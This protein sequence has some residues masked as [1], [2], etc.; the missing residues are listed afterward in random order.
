[1]VYQPSSRASPVYSLSLIHS[2]PEELKEFQLNP[3]RDARK[4]RN[5]KPAHE[6]IYLR[7]RFRDGLDT[8]SQNFAPYNLGFQDHFDNSPFS[9]GQGPAITFEEI[10]NNSIGNVGDPNNADNS[11]QA[12]KDGQ[13]YQKTQT[14]ANDSNGQQPAPTVRFRKHR[15]KEFK[16]SVIKFFRERLI[17]CLSCISDAFDIDDEFQ[18]RKKRKPKNGEAGLNS[19][20]RHTSSTSQNIGNSNHDILHHEVGVPSI[21]NYTHKSHPPKEKKNNKPMTLTPPPRLGMQEPPQLLTEQ[22]LVTRARTE[23]SRSQFSYHSPIYL[24]PHRSFSEI[25][26]FDSTTTMNSD[27]QHVHS[28]EYSHPLGFP[29]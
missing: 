13:P 15:L 28:N 20:N 1:M 11:A 17:Q 2:T 24:Q 21:N 12:S 7:T 4:E 26:S 14:L 19:H 27:I 9:F 22:Q 3:E 10:Y 16:E 25:T 5:E 23:G 18:R 8:F 6:P 29:N